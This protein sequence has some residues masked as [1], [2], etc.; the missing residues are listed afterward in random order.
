MVMENVNEDVRDIPQ[1]KFK[2]YTTEGKFG[3][4]NLVLEGE[5]QKYF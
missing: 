3:I 1:K 5:D 4:S 2:E